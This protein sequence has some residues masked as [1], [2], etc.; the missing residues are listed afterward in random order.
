MKINPCHSLDK[1]RIYRFAATVLAVISLMGSLPLTA[2]AQEEHYGTTVAVLKADALT[3]KL[4][5]KAQGLSFTKNMADFGNV[6]VTVLDNADGS[7]ICHMP[8]LASIDAFATEINTVL[9]GTMSG[10]AFYY[11]DE[12]TGMFQTYPAMF[13]YQMNDTG[14]VR[15]YHKLLEALADKK[16]KDK[17]L[18]LDENCF[19]KVYAE[20]P[21]NIAANRYSLEGSCTTSLKGSSSNRIQNIQIA[22]SKINQM[23]L[24]PGQ[25]VS[26]STAFTPR[27]RANGYR[28]A[29]AYFNGKTI[30]SL[31][32]GICQASSTIYN[33]AMNSGLTILER[34]AHSMPVSYL[35]LGMDAAISSG[36]KDLRIRNDY[37]FPVLFEGYTEGK[38]VTVNIYT[39]EP[40]TT[41]IAYRL[42]AVRTGSLSAN[43]YLEISLNGN[44][45]ED[46]FIGTSKYNPHLPEEE[47][48]VED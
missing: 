7:R 33:A 23:V 48:T 36:T 35:P 8:D 47:D 42:H 19:D 6:V 3:Q 45:A 14:K 13:C 27:T 1:K 31:G 29:G 40:L 15:I 11:F 18:E 30:Q 12:A 9:L 44:V 17:E 43:T 10:D 37:P 20:I 46:R 2:R 5:I 21:E 4:T 28:E 24:Y 34:H 26:M 38:T 22:V 32:G 39:N 16:N 41:G 25:E